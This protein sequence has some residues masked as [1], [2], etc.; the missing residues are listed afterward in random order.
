MANPFVTEE[1]FP[2]VVKW[3]EVKTK[4]GVM[5]NMI[6]R[7]KA[8]EDRYKGSVNELQT[9]WAKPNW[10][11]SSSV[12]AKAYQADPITGELKFIWAIY[13][14]LVMD[15]FMRQWDAT[16]SDGKPVP[17]T[18]ENTAMLDPAI[19]AELVQTFLSK[20]NV[21]EKELGE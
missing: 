3:T 12:L 15:N 9:Q 16:D 2:I 21:S 7:D 4:G 10:K 13:R 5:A 8:T 11:H 19:A 17:C 6:I 18:S 1:L 14:S 20:T